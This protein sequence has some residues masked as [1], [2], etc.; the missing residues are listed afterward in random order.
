[1]VSVLITLSS[2]LLEQGVL[3]MES[4]K[5]QLRASHLPLRILVGLLF[6]LANELS[7]PLHWRLESHIFFFSS[8]C[9]D[10]EKL[11]RGASSNRLE[12]RGLGSGYPSKGHYYRMMMKIWPRWW[13][14]SHP[15][16]TD[17]TRKKETHFK[18]QECLGG[19]SKQGTGTGISRSGKG[20][21]GS[22]HASPRAEL[23]P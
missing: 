6:V 1:M 20:V 21:S 5:G 3:R 13:C 23:A 12:G 22:S 7:Y 9:F 16:R 11:L 10:N 4:E 14:W 19:G 17:S 15:E 18:L 2:E 8:S